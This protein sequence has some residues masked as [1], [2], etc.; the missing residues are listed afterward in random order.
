MTVA[1]IFTCAGLELTEAEISFF[2]ETDPFGFILFADNIDTPAQIRALTSSLRDCVGRD[3]A[4]ILIDQEGGR[5]ARL[6]PP[7][8]REAPPAKVFGDLALKDMDAAKRAAWVNARLFAAE[9]T[10]LGIDVD[11]APVLDLSIPGAHDVIGDRSFGGN[12]ELVVSVARAFAEGLM[13]GGV[14]PMIKHVPGHGRAM[15]DSHKELP[16]VDLPRDQ[17]EATDFAPFKGLADMPLAMT[18][19]ILFPQIDA[20]RPA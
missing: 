13:A 17:L 2:K 16:S 1:T 8:W 9:L 10:D 11:C 6:T 12:P 15:A 3:D 20:E 14:L 7:Q 18:A 4:P 19:H 5:V